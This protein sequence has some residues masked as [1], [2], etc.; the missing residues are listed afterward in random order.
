MEA[1]QAQCRDAEQYPQNMPLSGHL[2]YTVDLKYTQLNDQ[3]Y[4]LFKEEKGTLEFLEFSEGG[5]GS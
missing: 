5:K 1:L 4:R 3:I 2:K